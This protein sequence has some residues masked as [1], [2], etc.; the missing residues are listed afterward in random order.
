M[1]HV[2]FLLGYDEENGSYMS[3]MKD[4]IAYRFEIKEV[5]GKGSFGHVVKVCLHLVMSANNSLCYILVVLPSFL[6]TSCRETRV[7]SQFKTFAGSL[8]PF[9]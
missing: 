5:L 3:V 9:S 8:L 4:H 2:F 1:F 6:L 7:C